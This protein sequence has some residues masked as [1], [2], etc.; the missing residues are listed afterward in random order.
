MSGS[1]CF[2]SDLIEVFRTNNG[3]VFQSDRE[4]CLFVDFGGKITK[5][6]IT[7]LQRLRL[8]VKKLDFNLMLSGSSRPD[9]ELITISSSDHCYLL[10]AVDCINFLDLLEG[11]FVMFD[12]N[13]ILKDRL[14]RIVV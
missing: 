1:I 12:L 11:T 6:S 7:C 3:V 5:Y 10:S 2:S 14:Q 8:R 13:N 4:N 9:F